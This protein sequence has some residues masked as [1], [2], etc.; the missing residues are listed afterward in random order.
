MP[1]A[2]PLSADLSNELAAALGQFVIHSPTAFAF[3]GEAPVD[4]RAVRRRRRRSR[5]A[6]IRCSAAIQAKFYD[7]LLRATVWQAGGGSARR[8]TA[9]SSDPAFARRLAAANAGREHW[10]GGWVI[11]QFGPN[12]QVFVRKGD[13]ERVAMPGAFVYAGPPGQAP[14]IGAAVSLRAPHETFDVQPG[15]YFAFGDTLDETGRQPEPAACLFPLRARGRS[16]ARRCPD[17]RPQPL[18]DTL[19][20]QDAHPA[21]AL[22]AHR[23][24]GALCRCAL[25]PDHRA[26]RGRTG[27]Q[28]TARAH[29]ATFHQ[30]PVAG[31]R[32]GR[33]AGVGRELRIASQPARR[34][35]HRR[36]LASRRGAGHA[37]PL[38]GDRGAF[39][40]AGLDFRRPWLGP[41]GVDPFTTPERARLP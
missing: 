37:K 1:D 2:A 3:A 39:S 34:R 40:A 18:P 16:V 27:R 14:Q 41:G 23:H 20:A 13:R 32:R 11:H 24:V 36:C 8:G 33:R 30:A 19:P 25:L 31:R 38:G 26:H 21:R 9:S 17:R 7:A 6:R 22:R 10:D 4:V 28:D 5:T 15:Y 12:G 35:G 29:H